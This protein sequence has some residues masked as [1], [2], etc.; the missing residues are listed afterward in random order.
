MD[1]DSGEPKDELAGAAKVWCEQNGAQIT[2]VSEFLQ[3]E[4]DKLTKAIQNGIDRYNEQ[5]VSRAQK[6]HTLLIS[7]RNKLNTKITAGLCDSGVAN[8]HLDK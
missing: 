5:A 1:L 7:K 3:M 8:G 2:T 6:V 4:D